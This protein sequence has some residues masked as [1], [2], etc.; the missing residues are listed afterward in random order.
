VVREAKEF[1]PFPREGTVT[2]PE[3]EN[4]LQCRGKALWEAEKGIGGL[5][6]TGFPKPFRVGR[7]IRYLAEDIYAWIEKQ[8]AG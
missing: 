1:R 5:A 8:K 3:V 7:Y 4:F 2:K 6:K